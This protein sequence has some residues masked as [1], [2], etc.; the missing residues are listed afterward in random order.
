MMTT[1]PL[2]TTQQPGFLRRH[3]VVAIL[4]VLVL[5][6]IGAVAGFAAYLNA[7]LDD[8]AY[9]DSTLNPEQRPARPTG[10]AA[11]AQNILLLGTDEGNGPSVAQELADGEWTAG[12]FRTDTIMLLHVSPDR[13]RAFVVSLPRD[14]Y[15]PIPGHGRQ[16]INAAFSFGGPDLSVRTIE[17]LTGVY[18][19]H[20][21][22]MDW[23][24]FQAVTDAIGGVE[25]VVAETYTDP[26]N[27]RTVPA[28]RHHLEGEEALRYVRTR[29]GLAGGDFDRIKRQQN[30]LRAVTQKAVS[31]GTL[32]NPITLS[33][34]LQALTDNI[35]VDS[36]FGPAEMRRLALDLRAV[37]PGDLE[38]LTAPMRGYDDV[39]GVGSVVLL[40]RTEGRVLWRSVRDDDV[41]SY[42]DRYGGDTLPAADR[43][44]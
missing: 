14:S 29:Y 17:D 31:G 40:D 34:L 15:V 5:L 6:L 18:I 24:G 43:V 11:R 13:G 12:A 22:I 19:D 3:K 38:Y 8:F 1:D 41:T 23:T 30:F 37:G 35:T 27:N 39:D 32:A 4:A 25:V 33:N 26:R 44:R 7:Q 36:G 2:T 9:Y 16:K 20:V 28:G 21:A 10:D 42:L